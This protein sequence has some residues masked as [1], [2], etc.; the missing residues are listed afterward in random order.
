MDKYPL[1]TAMQNCVPTDKKCYKLPGID[2]WYEWPNDQ[3]WP[4]M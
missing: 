3:K 4:K 2:K 1:V